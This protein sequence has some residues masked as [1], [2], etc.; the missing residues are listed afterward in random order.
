MMKQQATAFPEGGNAP[1]AGTKSQNVHRTLVGG[2]T[3]LHNAG[4][5]G[6]EM[7]ESTAIVAAPLSA[8]AT[9][10]QKFT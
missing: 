2:T 3:T 9:G 6:N 4:V 5:G 8:M 7:G 10:Q 1:T